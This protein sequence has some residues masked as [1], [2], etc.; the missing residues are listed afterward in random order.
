MRLTDVKVV[1]VENGGNVKGVASIV[2]DNEICVRDIKLVQGDTELVIIMPSRK[3]L[4]GDFK[5]IT[6]PTTTEA[7]EKIQKAIIEEYKQIV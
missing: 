7:R 3:M 5:N 1:K 2:I 4:N 6:H